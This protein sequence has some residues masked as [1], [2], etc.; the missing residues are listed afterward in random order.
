MSNP[1][2][3]TFGIVP[4]VLAGR[5]QM[6]ED[7]RRAFDNWPGD[8]NLASIF[9]GP[10]G[11]GKTAMLSCI[12][13]I[14]MEKGWIVAD[15]TAA[16]GML[17]D[18]LQR[19]LDVA[20]EVIGAESG[21]HL[22]GLEIGSILGLSWSLDSQRQANWRSKM[23]ELL[24]RLKERDIGL[25]ITI[26]EVRPDIIEMITFAQV[27]QLLIRENDK[28]A[29]AMAGLPIYVGELLSDNGASFLRRARQHYIGKIS[30]SEVRDAFRQTVESEG[31]TIE[32]Q[33]L[34]K[35]VTAADGFA[36]MMQLVGYEMWNASG[37]CELITASDA[38]MGIQYARADFRKGVLSSTY[39]DLSDGDVRFL[40]AM[41]ADKEYSSITDIAARIGKTP[42][43]ASTYKK[44]LLQAGVI[45]E[46]QRSKV[47]FAIPMFRGYLEDMA[48]EE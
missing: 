29:L 41:L 30:E 45:E 8:P 22:T 7:M 33:A 16:E 21:K 46:V 43:Y 39:R 18:I 35:A 28:V 38:D 34:D 25:L 10:R 31:K 44:R 5:G 24:R 26:D 4:P 36:Y 23:S 2:T 40:T 17:E 3:P 14:A 1:F 47:S 6:L 32:F 12:G 11:S 19:T 27:Y 42:G 13:D 48:S 9:I 20:S 37:N 15:T